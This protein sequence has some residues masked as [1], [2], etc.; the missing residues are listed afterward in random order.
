MIVLSGIL[1]TVC[2]ADLLAN[3]LPSSPSSAP[4]CS[5]AYLVAFPGSG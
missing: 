2:P 3:Y 4:S 5:T 1:L